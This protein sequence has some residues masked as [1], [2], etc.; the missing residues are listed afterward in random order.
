[1]YSMT[2]Y[3]EMK[4]QYESY[5][6]VMEMKSLNNKYLELRFHLPYGFESM[7][8]SFR[9]MLKGKISRGKV[10]VYLKID[11]ERSIELSHIKEMIIYY[12][13]I[14][15]EAEREIGEKIDFSINDIISLKNYLS[16]YEN[17]GTFQAIPLEFL[18]NIFKELI[19]KLI[20]E[21][22]IEGEATKISIEGC[23]EE[24]DESL[25]IIENRHPEV[26]ESFKKQL[27]DKIAELI[28]AQMDEA[29]IMMEVG[30]YANKIDIN[31]EISRIK[32]HIR[33]MRTLIDLNEPVG[34]TLDFIAQE[35]NR[36]VNTIGSKVPDYEISKEVVNVKASL[37]K[38]K[39]QVRNIE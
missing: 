3:A 30:I 1:M 14:I 27:K 31:E 36:E 22:L 4:T 11:A 18:K 8:Y 2:G 39:E 21:K 9:K 38:I 34:R 16:P 23:I 10:D 32:E 33:K 17:N 24:I 15:K 7:E 20:E 25:K 35:I 12:Y 28:D 6:I 37:E 29:R 26:V 5:N 19:E 13:D